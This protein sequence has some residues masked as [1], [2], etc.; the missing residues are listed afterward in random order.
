MELKREWKGRSEELRES[1][2]VQL[3]SC[4]NEYGKSRKVV[5]VTL[6]FEITG[7][8]FFKDYFFEGYKADVVRGT[9]PLEVAEPAYINEVSKALKGG[10]MKVYSTRDPVLEGI[11]R[12]ELPCYADAPE[13][14]IVETKS[15][16]KIP[17]A[18]GCADDEVIQAEP[19]TDRN[20]LPKK[21][22]V[23]SRGTV[24]LDTMRAWKREMDFVYAGGEFA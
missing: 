1:V 15:S 10:Y 12:G 20:T 19:A 2:L 17:A 22:T 6:V 24:S 9:S 13:K 7:Q 14:K 16:G 8:E 21:V 4:R 18:E 3:F 11:E 5:R 23:L